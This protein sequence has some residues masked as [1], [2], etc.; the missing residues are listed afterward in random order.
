MQ[1]RKRRPRFCRMRPSALVSPPT[2][3]VQKVVAAV[4]LLGGSSQESVAP[5]QGAF[6]ERTDSD[7]ESTALEPSSVILPVVTLG[8]ADAC[9]H[10]S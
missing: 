1:K 3:E 7:S 2:E 8:T 4:N 9:W 10:L 5:S 6:E